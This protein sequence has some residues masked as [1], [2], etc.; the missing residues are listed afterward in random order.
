MRYYWYYTRCQFIYL[1]LCVVRNVR[2]C[3]VWRRK[4]HVLCFVFAFHDCCSLPA[5]GLQTRRETL[6][7]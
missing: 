3:I 6:V 1:Y 2:V 4:T 5:L 7:H